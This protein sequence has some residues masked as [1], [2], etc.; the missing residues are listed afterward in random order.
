MLIEGPAFGG[1]PG[2]PEFAGGPKSA[3]GPEL[4]GRPELAGGPELGIEV[5]GPL[6]LVLTEGPS[7][8][9]T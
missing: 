6:P 4:P 7:G 3:G 8:I 5:S 9:D 1:G 2:G